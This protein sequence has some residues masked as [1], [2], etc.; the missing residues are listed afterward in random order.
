M[1]VNE[2]LINYMY[3]G[4]FDET[5]LNT[6]LERENLTKKQA[7]RDSFKILTSKLSYFSGEKK[8]SIFILNC[9]KLISLLC[10]N[11]KM[12]LD[13]IECNRIR[14]KKSREIILSYYQKNKNELLLQ[15]ANELDEIVLD[16]N[17]DYES[18]IILIKKLID[19]KENVEIIKKFINVNKTSILENNDGLFEYVFN[20]IISCL[21]QKSTDIYYYI[22]LLKVVYNSKIDKNHYIN[23]LNKYYSKDNILTKEIFSIINGD[24]RSLSLEEIL[25]K[26]YGIIDNNKNHTTICNNITKNYYENIITID[27]KRTV[28]RDDGLSIIRDGG[29]YIVGIHIADVAS[30]L[31]YGSIDEFYAKKNF[32]SMNLYNGKKIMMMNPIL[33]KNLS[34]EEYLPRK[35]L[36][37]F[38]IFNNSG[39]IIDY[40]LK[41]NDISV[42][43][44]LTYD[45]TANII[46]GNVSSMFYKDLNDLYYLAKA[47]N[48]NEDN[49][50][51]DK[52][53][54]K[55]YLIVRQFM[56][57][58][59]KIIAQIANDNNIPFIY[60]IQNKEY[61]TNLINSMN[62]S[63]DEYT[64]KT[65]KGI[66]LDSKYSI[67]PSYHYGLHL[68]KYA[69]S[70][71]PL[72]RY[73]DI[74]GQYILHQ[75]YFKDVNSYID[76][77]SLSDTVDYFNERN[78]ELSLLESEYKREAR[79]I[80]K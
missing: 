27:E 77:D 6:L 41:E 18:L 79:L 65:L 76:L 16:K 22:T 46:N 56:I 49:V 48:H 53:I 36:S 31:T 4:Y 44:N 15:A 12:N 66:F 57:I 55:S 3:C 2:S 64:A 38:V 73:P 42:S 80:K 45:E 33:G 70:A 39:E 29:N 10:E 51:S 58:Y 5:S 20:K 35:V 59:N 67:T 23:I 54:D 71:C 72:R 40:Y 75:L 37:L 52:I 47:M 21:Q 13:E 24:R 68:E 7:I 11:E 26:K 8:Y 62:V 28:L 61:F 63:I 17:F 74:Y 14:I 69:K 9:V 19:K 1:R 60:T 43:K 50:Q 34:L 25:Y 30:T 32:K 78:L